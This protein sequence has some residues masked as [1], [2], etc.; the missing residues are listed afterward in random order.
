MYDDTP[1]CAPLRDE[2]LECFTACNI[3]EAKTFK[4]DHC[5]QEE[6][7]YIRECDTSDEDSLVT[8]VNGNDDYRTF[9]ENPI[10]ETFENLFENPIYDMPR[11]GSVDLESL[12]DLGREGECSNFPYDYSEPCHSEP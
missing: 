8:D 6:V 3:F 5:E 7:S 9:I 10:Y 11:K 12:G 2:A 4:N 1:P